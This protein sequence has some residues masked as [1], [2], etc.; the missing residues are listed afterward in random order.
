ML[1]EIQYTLI[2]DNFFY[3]YGFNLDDLSLL[4]VSPVL[5]YLNSD[6]DKLSILRDNR[7]KSGVYR[8]TNLTNGKSYIGSSVNLSRRLSQYYNIN[9]LT[10][11]RQNS[12]IHRAILKYGYSKFKLDILEYCD[13]KDTI[14]REQYY[15]DTIKPEYNILQYAGS[16]TGF[17][18]SSESIEKIR[19]KK[20]GRK[21][22]IETLAKMMG[23]TH[24]E[25]TKNK[26][27][28]ILAT[29]EVRE[30]MVNAFSKRRGVKVSEETYSK[31]IS[32]QK[33]RDWVPRAGFK[34]EVYDLTNNLVTKYDSINKAASALDIP[35][36]TIARRIK[37]NTE[38]PY[39]DR[40]VFKALPF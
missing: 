3:L 28:N 30:K 11:Y 8:W 20:I 5:S 2:S 38:K 29:E 31:M 14:K 34:V 12:H 33:N 36:S 40:Y 15:M 21:H 4:T 35:K 18:H 32:A 6:T 10:K 24:S 7:C 39:N 23:R 22:T 9:M 37:L 19:M 27:K 1:V 16:N 17:V 25:A 13:K 26:I